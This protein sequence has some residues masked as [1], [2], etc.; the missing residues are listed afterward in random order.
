MSLEQRT[1]NITLTDNYTY[2]EANQLT[3]VNGEHP[4][5]D[6]AGNLTGSDAGA[7]F[8]YNAADQTL[9]AQPRADHGLREEFV[10]RGVGQAERA[11]AGPVARHLVVED[12][13][14]APLLPC[15]EEPDEVVGTVT[16][17]R[18]TIGLI[19][20]TVG[21]A[22]TTSFTRDPAGDLLGQRGPLG[23]HF[24]IRDGVGSI[25]AL[26]DANGVVIGTYE[27]DPFGRVTSADLDVFNPFRFAGYYLDGTGL[28]HTGERYYDPSLGRFTQQDPLYDPLDSKLWNRYLYVGNDPVN[29]TDPA[30]LCPFGTNPNGRCRGHRIADG[31]KRCLAGVESILLPAGLG[32]GIGYGPWELA[33]ALEAT[34][35][36][37]TPAGVAAIAHSSG[38]LSGSLITGGV[39]VVSVVAVGCAKGKG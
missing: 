38:A 36:L 17:V 23:N 16:F 39:I 9:S 32:F 25:V 13:I 8:T 15:T 18:S 19:G 26:T 34:G 24:Y 1:R 12:P 10:Y 29:Y 37:G 2:N 14:C 27:Y 5:Y 6:A 28:Y 11:S 22:A 7:E 33:H 3:V 35:K 20:E 21:G 4:T 30:G 31:A